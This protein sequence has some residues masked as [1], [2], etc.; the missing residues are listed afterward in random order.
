MWHVE[1]LSLTT[2]FLGGLISFLSPCVLPLL[3]VYL[4]L[5]TGLSTTEI[6]RGGSKLRILIYTLIFISGFS[7]IYI[8]MGIGS[9]VLATIFLDHGDIWRTTGGVFLIIF[10]G[11]LIGVIRSG[12]LMREFRLNIKLQKIGS[13]IGAFLVGVG[14]AAGWSPCIGPI[15]GSILIYSSMT[16][17]TWQSLKMLSAYSLGLAVPFLISSLVIESVMR[18]L[19]KYIGLFRWINY[20]LGFILIVIGITMVLGI[21]LPMK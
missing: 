18:Y 10:G 1:E 15:L 9:S 7:T 14:F 19:R 13:P 21:D 4:S 5:I 8:S 3:P 16:G 12:I 6:S 20:V 2:A 11:V 17:S